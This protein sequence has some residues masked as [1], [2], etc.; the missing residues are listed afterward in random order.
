MP[1][2]I[3][4]WVHIAMLLASLHKSFAIEIGCVK[5][6]YGAPLASDCEALLKS[7]ADIDDD[8]PRLFDEEQLRATGDLNFPGVKNDYPTKVVQVPAYWSLSQ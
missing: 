3:W 1:L 7:F 4:C 2:L 8:R 6:F 5:E